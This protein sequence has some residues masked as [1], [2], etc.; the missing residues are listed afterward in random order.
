[1]YNLEIKDKHFEVISVF[2]SPS[3][4][5]S[6]FED[7]GLNFIADCIL[8]DGY[9]DIK[10]Y[11]VNNQIFTALMLDPFI[12]LAGDVQS[13]EGRDLIRSFPRGK[14]LVLPRKF[15]D[16]DV[17]NFNLK[18]YERTELEV[19]CLK[20]ALANNEAQLKI[21]KIDS[22]IL[23]LLDVDSSIC[24]YHFKNYGNMSD[25]LNRGVGFVG[26]INGN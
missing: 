16:K 4:I 23:G 18:P 20:S 26:L 17:L 6:L 14:S 13:V 11:K 19:K 1:M 12:F 24:K 2:K 15:Q 7:H 9:G 3:N 10:R 8:Q 21:L 25:F 22:E 5:C